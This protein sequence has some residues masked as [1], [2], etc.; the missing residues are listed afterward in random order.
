[1]VMGFEANQNIRFLVAQSI[2]ISRW[3]YCIEFR[4]ILGAT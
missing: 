2:R 1:M 4:N 3:I